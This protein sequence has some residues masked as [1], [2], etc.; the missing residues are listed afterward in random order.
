MGCWD[1]TCGI[2]YTPIYEGERAVMVLI[3]RDK[4]FALCCEH[5]EAEPLKKGHPGW[6]SIPARGHAFGHD[7]SDY[8]A[9][10]DIIRGKYSGIGWIDGKEEGW[11]QK[12]VYGD[13][14]RYSYKVD[15]VE[16]NDFNLTIFF[17][18]DV[19][20]QIVKDFPEEEKRLGWA[21]K[22]MLETR[23]SFDREFDFTEDFKKS[24]TELITVCNFASKTRRDVLSAHF[25]GGKQDSFWGDTSKYHKF[26][27]KKITQHVKLMEKKERPDE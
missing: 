2:T 8:R 15:E 19:W 27:A 22:E 11:T 3:D 13:P 12:G 20:D 24:L 6:Y 7:R 16:H 1:E 18:E 17:H 25:S 21:F 26:I 14:R 9:V 10:L 23:R 4:L 5:R